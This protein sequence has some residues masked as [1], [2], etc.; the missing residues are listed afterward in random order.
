MRLSQKGAGG[1]YILS[2][3]AAMPC[4]FRD[5]LCNIFVFGVAKI[6]KNITKYVAGIKIFWLYAKCGVQR[7]CFYVVL[8]TEV[9]R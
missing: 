3:P 7:Y 8:K 4:G 9:L 2:A 1:F 6:P 5:V